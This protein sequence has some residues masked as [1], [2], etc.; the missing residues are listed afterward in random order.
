MKLTH[1]DNGKYIKPKTVKWIDW[2]TLSLDELV[3]Y[4][5]NKFKFDSSGT[6]KAVS[7]LIEFYEKN[8]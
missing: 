3:E 7:K 2:N 5:K 1:D 6:S 4:L 8:K